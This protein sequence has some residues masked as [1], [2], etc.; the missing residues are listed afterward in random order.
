MSPKMMLLTTL[1]PAALVVSV[2]AVGLVIARRGAR[3]QTTPVGEP[4]LR[5][6]EH[7]PAWVAVMTVVMAFLFGAPFILGKWP[8]L[9]P[10]LGEE[11][12]V[13][14]AIAAAA[15]AFVVAGV[16]GAAA[17]KARRAAPAGP[18]ADVGL[19]LRLPVAAMVVAAV[20]TVAIGVGLRFTALRSAFENQVGIGLAA[21]ALL[22]VIALG[23]AAM[24][25]GLERVA[26]RV[27]NAGLPFALGF[28]ATLSVPGLFMS[29]SAKLAQ[30]GLVLAMGPGLVSLAGMFFRGT[31]IRAGAFAGVA[32]IFVPIHVTL[33]L[34]AHFYAEAP[35]ATTIL[36]CVAPAAIFV[37]LLPPLRIKLAERPVLAAIV[38]G[39]LSIV[40][41]AAAVGI[42]AM[43]Y[44]AE[45]KNQDPGTDMYGLT[46]VAR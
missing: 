44:L 22:G 35:L 31:V 21:W 45:S 10:V 28:I 13:Y 3:A 5:H 23:M 32:T 20:A 30:L 2:I 16:V 14:V 33:W 12:I 25:L 4:D 29:S 27:R 6:G 7:W 37:S 34:T 42:A 1:L 41:M 39:V 8:P 19:G 15:A 9:P 24:T 18:A 40:V 36:A 11:W 26:C 17:V 46:Q 43:T 38:P